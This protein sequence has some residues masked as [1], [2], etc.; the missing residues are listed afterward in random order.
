[1]LAVVRSKS[2]P[3]DSGR[4]LVGVWIGGVWN[5]R[6]PESETYFSEAKSSRKIPEIPQ[7]ER[8]F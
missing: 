8:F 4:H 2:L 1:M 7:K 5:G 6:F 3:K